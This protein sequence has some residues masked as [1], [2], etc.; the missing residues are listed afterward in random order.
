MDEA[1]RHERVTKGPS[2]LVCAACG[3]AVDGTS[4]VP[5]PAPAGS[6]TFI[7][8]VG[9]DQRTLAGMGVALVIA[10]VVQA[11]LPMVAYITRMLGCLAH[12]MGHAAMGWALGR[13]SIPSFD[14]VYGGGVTVVGDRYTLL[15][16]AY[17]ALI[18]TFLWSRRRNRLALGVIGGLTAA[19]LLL[20]YS[21]EWSHLAFIAA[22]NWGRLALGGI[23]LFR[24]LTGVSVVHGVERWL[25]A[26]IGWLQIVQA[27]SEAWD[28]IYDED[29]RERY[30][31]GKG[32]LDN[33]WVFL[34]EE[35]FLRLETVAAWH[36]VLGFAVPLGA[37]AGW[38]WRA[39]L[40]RAWRAVV[41]TGP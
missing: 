40:L 8:I 29:E 12:E 37:W 30:F 35:L 39:T 3:A 32:G 14:L 6:R 10:I 7:D 31:G 9:V 25:Y 17:L 38:R 1:C 16:F 24:A 27:Q 11:C 28:L 15:L 36:I 5:A 41:A 22:G 34:S 33:D 20:A 4:S 18:G 19:W 26:L 23:F 2:G 21:D 13:P